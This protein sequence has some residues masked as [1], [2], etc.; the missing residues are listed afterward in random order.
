[1]AAINFPL[2]LL[3]C[4]CKKVA[5]TQLRIPTNRKP[6]YVTLNEWLR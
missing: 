6:I 5:K 3:F 1:M 4:E 2:A